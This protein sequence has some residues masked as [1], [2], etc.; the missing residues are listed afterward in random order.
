MTRVLAPSGCGGE[1]TQ[2]ILHILAE[3]CTGLPNKVCPRLRDL[4]TAPARGITQPR[5]NL[6]REPC[7]EPYA[8]LTSVRYLQPTKR[9]AFREEIELVETFYVWYKSFCWQT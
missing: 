5:T 2:P 6:I 1:F 9:H 4:A 7:T 3:Y 8:T